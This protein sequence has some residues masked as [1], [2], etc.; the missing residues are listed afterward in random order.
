MRTQT[1]RMRLQ[2]RRAGVPAL[3]PSQGV[4]G[5]ELPVL[6]GFAGCPGCSRRDWP[7][8]GTAQWHVAGLPGWLP[9]TPQGVLRVGQS[10]GSGDGLAPLFWTL[11]SRTLHLPP[12]LSLQLSGW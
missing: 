4:C 12:H 8:K 2:P 10:P 9:T 1:G 7:V 6:W 3:E 11:G 5:V